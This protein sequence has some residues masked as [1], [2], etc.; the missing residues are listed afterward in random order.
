MLEILLDLIFSLTLILPGLSLLKLIRIRINMVERLSLS[1]ILSL[2]VIFTLLY[3]GCITHTFNVASLMVLAI[4]IGSFVYLFSSCIIKSKRLWFTLKTSS[5]LLTPEKIIV[6]AATI[7]LLIVYTGFLYS[8]A[9]LDSDVAHEYLPLAREIVRGNGFTYSN[10]YDYNVLIKPI[11]ASVLYAWTYMVSGST[12]SEFFRLMPLVP[13]LMLIVLTY[14]IAFSATKSKSIGIISTALLLV[15]PFHDRFLLYSAF[16]PDTFYYPLV[17]TSIYFL[18]E[19]V[20]SKRIDLLFW[21]GLG[22]GVANLLKAQTIYFV[23]AFLLVLTIWELRNFKKFSIALCFFTPFYV[24][25]LNILISNIRVLDILALSQTQLGLFLFLSILSA[26]SCYSTI[27][28]NSLKKNVNRYIITI[29]AKRVGLVFMPLLILSSLWYMSNLSIFG[30]LI[31]T[32]SINLP[33]YDWALGVLNSIN[34]PQL[35][36]SIWNYLAYFIFM[37]IDPSVMGYVMLVP[38]IVGLVFA[39]R[40]KFRNFNIFLLFGI[41]SVIII[42]SMAVTST[43]YYNPRDIFPLAPLLATLSAISITSITSNN[44]F[45]AFLLVI[46]FG[47]LNYI[48]SVFV[49][50]TSSL[51]KFGL[52]MSVLGDIVGLNLI[53]T[54]FE[55]SYSARPIFISENILKILV[56]S[57]VAA[58]PLLVIMIYKNRNLLIRHTEFVKLGFTSRRNAQTLPSRFFSSIQRVFLKKVFLVFLMLFVIFTPRSEILSTLG[59][60][61]GI[62]ENMLE[63]NYGDMYEFISSPDEINGGILTFKAPM[64]LPY[65]LPNIK[66]IDLAYP[67]NLAFLKDC[68]QSTITYETVFK[69]R[70]YG[71][72]HILV[73]IEYLRQLDTVLNFTHFRIIS[74]PEFATLSKTYGSWQLYDLH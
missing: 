51:T 3:L 69:L 52:L 48:H 12:S 32:S 56:L 19:Y 57:L 23:L 50:F 16:Y 31:W 53:Q 34:T 25:G 41:V 26:V 1:Y 18:L 72:H 49:L 70:Q 37:F 62:K 38:L 43:S 17:I 13:I 65:Y 55:L 29:L 4:L 58:S 45:F 73:N 7:G 63:M 21:T 11:G 24:L 64:G 60:L 9:I 28:R 54:S 20:Q 10:G 33:H 30:T 66:I 74:N 46:Y 36:A 59:G 22:L 71:I 6:I 35:T 61:Q 14:G 5:A 39:F 15:F 40:N 27:S 67:A 47:L 42:A 44:K 2:T 8:R 68:Y